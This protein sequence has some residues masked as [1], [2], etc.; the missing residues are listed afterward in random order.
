MRQSAKI[1]SIAW[2]LLLDARAWRAHVAAA[3]HGAPD[4]KGSPRN[5]FQQ[6]QTSKSSIYMMKES[7]SD[8]SASH[9]EQALQP[10]VV[11]RDVVKRFNEVSAVA[12]LSFTLERGSVT[13]LLG[14]NG[15]GKT[16]TIAMLLGLVTPTSGEIRVFGAER[17]SFPGGSA[18]YCCH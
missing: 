12:G 3:T 2:L 6:A 10:P 9:Q 15:A 16:T 13:A 5:L 18:L 1:N 7:S 4:K 11:L 8:C 17:K 14:G